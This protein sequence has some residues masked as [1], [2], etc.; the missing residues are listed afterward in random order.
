[1]GLL[2]NLLNPKAAIMYLALIPQFIEPGR[3]HVLAQGFLLGELAS[4]LSSLLKPPSVLM[5][6]FDYSERNVVLPDQAR[7][8]AGCP[9][10]V[11][12]GYQA[13]GHCYG[14]D[15]DEFALLDRRLS[16]TII[17]ELLPSVVQ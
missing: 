10:E 14:D 2:T 17:A 7:Q 4:R 16:H 8:F 5:N 9:H 13:G 1:M 6:Y 15:R 3:G 12:A 11:Q